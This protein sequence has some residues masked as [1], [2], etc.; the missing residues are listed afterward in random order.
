MAPGPGDSGLPGR[1]HPTRGRPP[2]G[3]HPA[4]HGA[5]RGGQ[6][7]NLAGHGHGRHS[8]GPRR[9]RHPDGPG[10]T[11]TRTARA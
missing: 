7:G 11:A 9:D 1:N 3:R 8:G 4:E 6:G 10:A 5:N 2:C